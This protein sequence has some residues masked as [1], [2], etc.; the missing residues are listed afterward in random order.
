[1][2]SW[3]AGQIRDPA[4][5]M[6]HA[7]VIPFTCVF[8][9]FLG[10][11]RGEIRKAAGLPSWRGFGW[12]CLFLA[13][14][15]IG[16]W[17]GYNRVSQVSAIGLIWSVP[18]A[19]WGRGVGRVMLFP[20]WILLFTVPLALDGFILH[21]RAFSADAAAA[22]LNGFGIKVVRLGTVLLS[23]MPGVEPIGVI[24]DQH[25]FPCALITVTGSGI[26]LFAPDEFVAG[27]DSRNVVRSLAGMAEAGLLKPLP[28]VIF[29]EGVAVLRPVATMTEAGTVALSPGVKFYLNVDGPC[30]G[31]R[32]LFSM[33]VIVSA[34]G[35]FMV[36]SSCIHKWLCR[37][38]Q[39]S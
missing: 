5:E 8:A 37:A 16:A 3:V 11:W 24:A 4:V 7:R 6:S 19:F 2:L 33:M 13:L 36:K 20:A 25:N 39:P 28:G 17:G 1:M 21:L 26:V 31:I 22:A 38:I 29:S 15:W 34:Y 14:A 23:F 10:W 12:A 9:V 32:S 18:Y 35:Y 30:S 27:I